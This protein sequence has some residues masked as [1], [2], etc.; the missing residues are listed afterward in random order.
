LADDWFDLGHSL[1][2]QSLRDVIEQCL[3]LE[4]GSKRMY[5]LDNVGTEASPRLR[6]IACGLKRTVI[7]RI[8][9]LRSKAPPVLAK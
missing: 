9:G 7:A 6:D 8:A 1:N 3:G 2:V 4:A 5:L